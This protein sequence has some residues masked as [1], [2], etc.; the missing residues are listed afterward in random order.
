MTSSG[1]ARATRLRGRPPGPGSGSRRRRRSP[2]GRAAASS[3]FD[4]ACPGPPTINDVRTT[5]RSRSAATTRASA[6]A[7]ARPYSVQG[8][9]DV[10]LDVRGALAAVEDDIGREV[11]EPCADRGRRARD[12]LGAV[13]DD[14]RRPL[15]R[16]GGRRCG[17]RRRDER[18]RAARARRQRRVP[19]PVPASPRERAA[20]APSRETRS[21]PVTCSFDRRPF[22][23]A[24]FAR[25]CLTHSITNATENAIAEP[26]Q[27]ALPRL[28]LELLAADV[29]EHRRV[30]RPEPAR[31][32]VV[33]EESMPRQA[34]RVAGRERHRGPTERDEPGDEDDVAAAFLELLLGPVEA[35]VRLLVPEQRVDR[36]LPR[37]LADPVRDVV[38]G[39]GASP[40]GRGS[41]EAD[42]R[43]RRRPAS[44]PAT[45]TS[46]SLGTSGKNASSTDTAKIAT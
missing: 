6:S 12:V 5:E 19:R 14:L 9:G 36:A 4:G 24:F 22:G 16:P 33:A 46:D 44:E 39:D 42:V 25:R 41:R 29:P 20:A 35:P 7:F 15:R 43:G 38:A 31:D 17:S 26:E 18:A 45:I 3:C 2:R 37:P 27:H 28:L 11:D 10:R 23:G 1:T 34:P 8:D 30:R 32:Q 13:D 21:P 40:G